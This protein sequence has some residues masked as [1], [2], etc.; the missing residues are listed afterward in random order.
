M[1]AE[2]QLAGRN[3]RFG[4]G[5]QPFTVLAIPDTR[6]DASS[7]NS[8]HR[9]FPPECLGFAMPAK[10]VLLVEDDPDIPIATTLPPARNAITPDGVIA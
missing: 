6:V 9:T 2:C 3:A 10:R 7:K 8:K 4:C 5:R 1:A